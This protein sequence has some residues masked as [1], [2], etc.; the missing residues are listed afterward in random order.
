MVS[1]ILLIAL[2]LFFA[3]LIPLFKGAVKSIILILAFLINLTISI[4]IFPYAI[5]KAII[6]KIANFLPPVGINLFV[7]PV[8][9]TLSIL[10]SGIG[11]LG[12]IY[13]LKMEKT[14]PLNRFY[15]LYLLMLLGATGMSLTGDIFNMFV[16]LE[17][18]TISAYGLTSYSKNEIGLEAGMKY[19]LIGSLGANLV[20]VGVILL[21]TTTGSLNMA[22]IAMRINL[23]PK[24]VLTFAFI[25]FFVGFGI[26]A[27]LFPLNGWAPDALEGAPHSI[28][29]LLSSVISKVGLYAFFRFIITVMGLTNVKDIL[30]WFG[31]ATLFIGE[32]AA[33]RQKSLKRLLAYS[34]IAQ[35]GFIF[36]AI[37]VGTSLAVRGALFHIVNHALLSGMM[38]LIAGSIIKDTNN[39][40]I[41]SLRGLGSKSRT[42]AFAFTIGALGTLGF[43]PLNGFWSKFMMILGM[44]KGKAI[45]PVYFILFASLI[46]A[47]YYLRLVYIVYFSKSEQSINRMP[48]AVAFPVIVVLILIF[49]LGFFP[50]LMNGMLNGGVKD[51]L[52]RSWYIMSVFGG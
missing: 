5:H 36:S 1:P 6:V 44:M 12:A 35:L 50:S 26:E 7:G 37:S 23:V 20:L 18:T 31:I 24:A 33:L 3:F 48:F 16:F 27:E 45:I 13:L 22:D 41:E 29:I 34:S 21:Y 52:N 42:L 40:N 17:I 46:E 51:V 28:S 38:F 15:A 9:I 49:L 10:I 14:P 39:W 30:I 25:L 4:L 2:P 43:P 32:L 47:V 11:L 19:L 8:G